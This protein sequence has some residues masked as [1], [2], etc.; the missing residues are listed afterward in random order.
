M[1]HSSTDYFHVALTPHSSYAL[2]PHLAFENATKKTRPQLQSGALVY[3]RIVSSHVHNKFQ[4]PELAC[5]NPSTGKTEGL[6]ELKGGTVFQI[7]LAMAARL[8]VRKQREDGGVAVLEALAQKWPFE[9]AIGRNGYVWVDAQDVKKTIV[10]GRAIVETDKQGL[11]V[12]A[13]ERLVKRLCRELGV[14]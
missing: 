11:P 8:L 6:G 12:D 13:Q 10:V 2:L 3:A 1:H 14:N 9:V 4:E 5:Y 7:S